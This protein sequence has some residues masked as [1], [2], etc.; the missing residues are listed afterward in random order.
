MKNPVWPSGPRV[1]VSN[2]GVPQSLLAGDAP[3][4][5][6][7]EGVKRVDLIIE[8]GKIAAILPSGSTPAGAVFDADNG[9]AW[10]TFADLVWSKNRNGRESSL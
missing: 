7:S 6:N 9:Q 1:H 3:S 4:L 2:V 8:H 10:P 5:A